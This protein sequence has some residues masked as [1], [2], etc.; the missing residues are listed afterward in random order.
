MYSMTERCVR[1][2][3]ILGRLRRFANAE[4]GVKIANLLK[5]VRL[6]HGS[7][8]AVLECMY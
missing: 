2:A 8:K 6:R 1:M 3:D 7:G 4:D 5:T